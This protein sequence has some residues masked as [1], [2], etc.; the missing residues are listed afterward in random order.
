IGPTGTDWVFTGTMRFPNDVFALFH[1]GTGL[2]GQERG[3]LEA[4]GDGGSLF[5]D[6]PWH[7]DEPGIVLTRGEEVERIEI[8]HADSYVLELEN[9]SDAIRGEAELLLGREDAV[10]QART[11]EALFRSAETGHPVAL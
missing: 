9:M 4:I 3:E 2:V 8:E 1:C 7:V 5:L 11:L 6:D 10:A